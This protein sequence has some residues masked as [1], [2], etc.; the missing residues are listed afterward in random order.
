MAN[1][2]IEERSNEKIGILCSVFCVC[3]DERIG[4]AARAARRAHWRSIADACGAEPEF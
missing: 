3:S 4:A 1:F 2:Q